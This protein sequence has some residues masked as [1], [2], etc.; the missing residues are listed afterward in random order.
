MISLRLQ[1][2]RAC[3]QLLI[4]ISRYTELWEGFKQSKDSKRD[5]LLAASP[6]RVTNNLIDREHRI[7]HAYSWIKEYFYEKFLDGYQQRWV[8][9]LTAPRLSSLSSDYCSSKKSLKVT[10][11]SSLCDWCSGIIANRRRIMMLAANIYQ[12]QSTCIK[13]GVWI[14]L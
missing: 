4:K 9:Q 10:L 14:N 6:N 1:V 5:V 13:L 2:I 3:Y 12:V 11:E 7:T 8:M